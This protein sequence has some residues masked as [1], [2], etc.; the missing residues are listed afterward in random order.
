MDTEKLRRLLR[1]REPENLKLDFKRKLYAINHSDPKVRDVQWDEFIR[2]VL[3]LAN[4]NIGTVGQEGH[5]VVG[6]ADKLNQQGTRDLYDVGDVKLSAQQILQKVNAASRPRL[7]DLDIETVVLEEKR[8]LVITIPPTPYLHETTRTLKTPKTTYQENTVFIRRGESIRPASTSERQ[9][10]LAEKFER[11]GMREGSEIKR[12]HFAPDLIR[13]HRERLAE[14][15][16]YARWAD[17][18]PDESYIDSAGF[19]LP[20]FASPY[21]DIGGVPAELLECI[22]SCQRLLILGEPGMGKTVGLERAMWELSASK[23][24]L[25]PIFIPLIQYDGNLVAAIKVALNE[26]GV[27][28]VTSATEVEK[29]VHDY[30][31]VFLFDGLNEV[32]GNYRDKLYAELASFIRAHPA[33]PCVI[34]SRSQDDLWRRFHSREMIEDAVV[35]QRITDEQVVEYLV[36][37]LGEGMGHELHDRLNEA[38]RGLARIPL[39]LWLIKE[40]G[41]AGEELPGNRG[42]LFDRF[43]KQ[44]L[45]R[46]QKLPDLATIPLHQKTRALSHLAFH[47]QKNHRLTCDRDEA[48]QVIEGL[49][50]SVRGDLVIGESLRNGLLLGE[51]RLH[52]M[53]QA[54][55]EYFVAIRLRNLISSLKIPKSKA[56]ARLKVY[57]SA[58]AFKRQLRKWAEDGWW[59]EAIVQLAGITDQPMFVA[60]Q[61]LCSNPWLAYWCSIEGQP[62]ST[63]MQAQIE[64]QTVERLKSPRLEERLRV[65]RELAR[66]ENPRTINHLIVALDD[67][68]NSVQEL[69]SYTLARLGQPSVDPLL[70]SLRSATEGARRATTRTLGAIWDFPKIVELGTQDVPT[71]R[72]AAEALGK[73]GDNR[74]VLPLIAA[75]RDSDERV[76]IRAAQ[77]LGR[78]GDSR[79]VDPLMRALEQS[80]GRAGSRESA[81]ISEAL[82]AIGKPTD[83]PLL[84]GLKDPDSEVRKRALTALGRTWMLPAVAELAS[85]DP[86]TRRKAAR[87]LGKLSDERVADPLLAALRD[88]DQLVRWEATKALGYLWQLPDLL[89]LGDG[90]AEIRRAAALALSKLADARAVEPLIAALRDQDSAV[91]EYAADALGALGEMSIEPLTSLLSY[92][93]RRIRRSV[94]KAFAKIE[95]EKVLEILT[96]AIQDS[97]WRV[98]EMAVECLTEL[99]NR[100]VPALEVVLQSDDPEI[101]QLARVVLQR[102]GTV[103]AQTVLRFG[104]IGRTGSLDNAVH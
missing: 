104:S 89:K 12:V 59:A 34:T 2:D 1:Q 84:A 68:S 17:N 97:R 74:A 95:D 50:E 26:T 91:R 14:R 103:R 43:V 37:H 70:D 98:R 45:K 92:K 62:L 64:Q 27:L 10:I 48:V 52:F 23:S 36:A 58:F 80:Y 29:L 69:A 78:I 32:A 28:N 7:P 51:T 72:R 49:Q 31:C 24:T 30:E 21:E 99:G 83:E 47:L 63:E 15:V 60:K 9:A 94:K 55:H 16:K 22:H 71:R 57:S 54:V 19:H 6:A 100:A 41:A 13:K 20:L 38:L 88:H 5:L 4:G 85:D 82:G 81:V 53:H 75:L 90:N 46:E 67:P 66:M 101:Q 93:D 40:A 56:I 11:F 61:V 33:S 42:E 87:K 65:I 8:I 77:S 76:R 25:V 86:E 79:A 35:I 102:I 73:V 3:A 44:V 18:S 96:S 39:L